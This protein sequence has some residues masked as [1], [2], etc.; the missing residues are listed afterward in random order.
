MKKFNKKEVV[1]DIKSRIFEN[2]K[3]K[4]LCLLLAFVMYFSVSIF[5]RSTKIY[6]SDLKIVDLKD[7]LII[8]NNIPEN[9]KII[10]KDKPQV[11]NRF[12]HILD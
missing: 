5:Q 4:L 9:I 11:F 3:I 10:A 1:K 7:Y 8:S 6:S 12:C 2:F